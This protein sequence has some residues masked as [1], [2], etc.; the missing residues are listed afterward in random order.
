MTRNASWSAKGARVRGAM[1]ILDQLEAEGQ[2]VW[3]EDSTLRIHPATGIQ[4]GDERIIL[5]LKP[6]ILSLLAF[7]RNQRATL[8]RYGDV[9][10]VDLRRY[11]K[12]LEVWLRFTPQE[13]ARMLGYPWTPEDLMNLGA[14]NASCP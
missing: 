13:Q 10:L 2:K 8:A 6:E 11:Q 7:T 12:G 3:A 5:D 14:L 9:D 4:E 1:A